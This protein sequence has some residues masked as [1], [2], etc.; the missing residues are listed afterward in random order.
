MNERTTRVFHAIIVLAMLAAVAFVPTDVTAQPFGPPSR[1]TCCIPENGTLECGQLTPDNCA[2]HPGAFSIGTGSCAHNPCLTSSTT[3]STR[4]VTTSSTSTSTSTSAPVTTSSTSTSTSTS[5]PVTTSST[6]TSTSTS[7]PVT[8][9]STST[10][11]STSTSSSTSTTLACCGSATHN[12][13]PTQLSFTTGIG[14]GNC[15]TALNT[16]GG[17]FTN[18]KCGGLYTGGGGNSVPLPY[19]VPDM[20]QS[21]TKVTACS[22]P[23]LTLSGTTPTEAGVGNICTQGAVSKR[24]TSCTAD[25]NCATPCTLN[26]DCF[27][28]GGT[29]VCVAGTCTTAV[30]SFEKC[31]NAGCLFGQPLPIPNSASTPTSVCVINVVAN[32]ASGTADCRSGASSLSLPLTSQLYLAGDLEPNAAGIQVCPVCT[33]TCSA[34]TNSKRPCTADADCPRGGGGAPAG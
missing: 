13:Q 22:D 10:S 33:F 8:T 27:S 3:T 11:T 26:S 34:G 17:T 31:T 18:L 25:S 5:A 7:A 23:A 24:G 16:A 20:G 1:V 12:V 15:G 4:P 30:C 21:F 32:N 19:A 29:G 2:R 28:G 6:S 14:S 9:S